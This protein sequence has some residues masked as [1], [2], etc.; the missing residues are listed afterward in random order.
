MFTLVIQTIWHALIGAAVF[1][2]TPDNRVT[3]S[4]SIVHLDHF[5]FFL[6][7]GL[8]ITKHILLIAWLYLVP[9]KH[10]KNMKDKGIYYERSLST[11]KANQ[12]KTSAGMKLDASST[13]SRIPIES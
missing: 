10:R 7:I 6:T 9:L 12:G 13:F 11:K 5:V 4:M 8:F 1:R 3:P 2:T